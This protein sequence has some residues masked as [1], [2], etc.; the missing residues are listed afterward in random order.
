MSF[1]VAI[2]P[3]ALLIFLMTKRN[4]TP[5]HVALPIAA[6]LVY[7]VQL[8]WFEADPNLVNATVV[9]GLL[10]AWTP[11]LIVWGAIFMF[12]TM[13]VTGAMDVV[14][15]WLNGVSTNCVAQLMIIGWAFSFL[16]E[17]A[18]GFGTPAALAAPILVG[19]GFP[20]LKVA[21]FCLVMNSVPVSFGAVG[22]PIWFG[23]GGLGLSES[24][25]LE[26]GAQT[27]LI[28]M[29]AALIVPVIALLFVVGWR[30]VRA[31]LGYVYLSIIACVVPYLLIAQVS[32]E[33]PALI[34]GAF[35]TV[36]SVWLAGRGIGLSREGNPPS[37]RARLPMP[38]LLKATFPLWGAVAILIVTRI[39]PLG[40]KGFLTDA[41]PV[42]EADLGSVG[43]VATSA[44]LVLSLNHIFAANINWAVQ[45]LYIPAFLPFF[46][47][48]CLAFLLY[49]TPAGQ[50]REIAADSHARMKNP[51]IALSA[52]LVMV[53]L[54]LA[55]GDTS[56]VVLI[57]TSFSEVIGAQWIYCA[58]L[59]GAL[60]S[61]FSG[62]ATISSL[63][64][65]GVQDSIAASLDL[66]RTLILS[67]QSVGG[68][69]GNMVCI[70]NIVA[71]CT[72]LG[73]S[74][75]EGDILKRT[76]VPMGAYA[77]IAAAAGA[78]L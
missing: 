48:S 23:L 77:A 55:G 20:A 6:L 47:V 75:Q 67:L 64:F 46:A 58:A 63:T 7:A 8:V 15:N 76:I 36:A 43:H 18:S 27:A 78:M 44:S 69:M 5:S 73:I 41:T 70:N 60:G 21:L 74:N 17:G 30:E 66:D 24:D 71:V 35:G 45:L 22:T 9:K 26:I 25:L 33:F 10:T 65:G 54:L 14:R 34:G 32:Y 61:F 51:I 57:G 2:A 49:R 3:I 59:L 38:D 13:E 37:E 31:N 50:I 68:A 72:I 16:I 42:L 52:A 40:L 29:A 19:L 1:L 11:I 56:L 4:S 62:S 28:H 12:R 53:Q 39:E